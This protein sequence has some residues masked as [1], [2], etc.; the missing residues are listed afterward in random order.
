MTLMWLHLQVEFSSEVMS[1]L[2]SSLSSLKPGSFLYKS[3]L[4]MET[5]F[6]TIMA[7][8][9]AWFDLE[10]PAKEEGNKEETRGNKEEQTGAIGDSLIKKEQETEADK[11][12]GEDLTTSTIQNW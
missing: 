8:R 5:N 12:V 9:F 1:F 11:K 10:T 2:R 7:E 6:I 3:A 4:T